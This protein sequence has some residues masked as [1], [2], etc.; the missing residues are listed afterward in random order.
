MENGRAEVMGFTGNFPWKWTRLGLR[1]VIARCW[2]R[3]PPFAMLR[4][5]FAIATPRLSRAKR[6]YALQ[7]KNYVRVCAARCAHVRLSADFGK[8][9][10]PPPRGRLDPPGRNYF[11]DRRQ[12][13][14][15]GNLTLAGGFLSLRHENTYR[16]IRI[17]RF[18]RCAGC[19]R[20]REQIVV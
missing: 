14:I 10:L 8:T 13:S 3:N 6:A 15:I 7:I 18:G 2:A 17:D 16:R 5:W 9:R 12:A 20:G 19:R 4:L 11:Y 1:L